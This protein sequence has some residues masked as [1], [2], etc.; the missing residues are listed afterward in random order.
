M[1]LNPSFPDQTHTTMI[2]LAL[3]APKDDLARYL[4]VREAHLENRHLH[5]SNR[6]GPVM[7]LGQRPTL[8]AGWIEEVLAAKARQKRQKARI[9]RLARR[10]QATW[11]PLAGTVLP[12]PHCGGRARFVQLWSLTVDALKRGDVLAGFMGCVRC[13]ECSARSATGTSAKAVALWNRRA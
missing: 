8:Y 1:R 11:P 3:P 6:I 7:N 9:T 4:A 2:T 13:E 10:K 5:C 12:C